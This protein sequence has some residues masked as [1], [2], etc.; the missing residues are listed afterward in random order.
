MVWILSAVDDDGDRRRTVDD[1]SDEQKVEIIGREERS[2]NGQVFGGTRQLESQ[3]ASRRVHQC[4]VGVIP[5]VAKIDY[6]LLD[7]VFDL[8]VAIAI[9]TGS[10]RWHWRSSGDT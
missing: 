3:S 7:A 2:G 1:Q 10:R 8:D 9:R 5:A 4:R 6:E